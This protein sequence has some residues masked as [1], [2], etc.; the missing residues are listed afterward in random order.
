MRTPLLWLVRSKRFF[1][2]QLR[3]KTTPAR[4]SRSIQSSISKKHVIDNRRH[5]GVSDVYSNLK[6]NRGSRTAH[7]IV[8][9]IS[10]LSRVVVVLRMCGS[11]GSRRAG[12]SIEKLHLGGCLP[13][14]LRNFQS[15]VSGSYV[16]EHT[17]DGQPCL[18]WFVRHF[19]AVVEDSPTDVRALNN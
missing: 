18:R 15:R 16:P 10:E 4:V 2:D 17:F 11:T 1:P 12:N 7:C 5:Q 9:A 6:S 13:R 14:D 19:T 3:A 8:L